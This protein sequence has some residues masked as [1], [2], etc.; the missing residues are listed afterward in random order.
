V[1]VEAR[2]RGLQIF[3]PER[4]DGPAVDRLAALGTD[5]L[6]VVAYGLILPRRSCGSRGMDASTFTPL[7]FHGTAGPLR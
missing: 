3:Q 5:A 2:S 6:V 1:K 7:S 4:L